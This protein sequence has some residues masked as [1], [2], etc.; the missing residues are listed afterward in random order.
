MKKTFC[1]LLVF[2]ILIHAQGQKNFSLSAS[3]N[4]DFLVRGLGLNN[5]GFG[6]FV[7]P[8]F[9]AKH[10]LQLRVEGSID[11]FLGSKLLMEDS[12]ANPVGGSTP[13]VLSFKAGPE[14]FV[15]KNISFAALYGYGQYYSFGKEYRSGNLKFALSTRPLKHSRL[16]VGFSF[17]QMTGVSYDVHFC[18]INLG[19]KIL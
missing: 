5:G 19:Y 6:I 4:F 18:G 16:L 3:G 15:T 14:Y 7:Q 17:T 2:S 9:F 10:K 12:L 8:N 13:A 11:Q 1:F